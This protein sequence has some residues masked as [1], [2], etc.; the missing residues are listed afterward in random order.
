MDLSLFRESTEKQTEGAPVYLGD[1]TFYVRRWGTPESQRYVKDLRRAL[2]GPYHKGQDGDENVLIAE[3]LAGY[4]V[5]GWEN[6]QEVGGDD[7]K[8][9]TKAARSLFLDPEYYLSLNAELF[10]QSQ[11]FDNYLYEEADED[12]EAL[13]KK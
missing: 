1:A 4:G 5:T 2:W 10:M 13:K 7:L 9:T 3:W 11:R 8:Y 6:V 12:A